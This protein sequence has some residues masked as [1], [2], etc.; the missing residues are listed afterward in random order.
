MIELIGDRLPRIM[1]SLF[2]PWSLPLMAFSALILTGA[3]LLMICGQGK[4]SFI[5]AL[6]MATSA[7]CV[8]GLTIMNIG[9]DL[10]IWGQLVI[11]T[12][13]QVGGLGIM[14]FSTGLMLFL[15]RSIS[16][17]S[18]FVLQDIFTYSP[19]SDFTSLVKRIVIFTVLFEFVGALLLFLRFV[20]TSPSWISALY[21]AIFHSISAFCNA[22]FSLFPDS[23]M[24][25][26]GDALVN[27]TMCGLIV[28]GGLGF[29]VMHEIYATLRKARDLRRFW[30]MLSL[31]TKVVTTSTAA[32]IVIGALLF[33]VSEWHVT[34]KG[35]RLSERLLSSLFQSVT[36]RTAGFNTLDFASMNNISI[37]VTMIFM[38]IG[39]SPGSTGGGIK[40]T[41]FMVLLALGWSR[42]RGFEQP[43]LFKR[44]VSN[45]SVNR[46]LV[47]FVVGVWI[48]VM[49]TVL[50]LV[51]E[52]GYKPYHET[53][54]YFMEYLFEVISAFGTV[55]LSMGVTPTLSGPG[56]LVIVLLM[57]IGRVGP[58]TVAMAVQA[59][60]VSYSYAEEKVMIG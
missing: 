30:N 25:F 9:T 5:D 43:F 1:R 44:T 50:L 2:T 55:G 40:T 38:F 48:V 14:T 42:F 37:F 17:R 53:E 45:D 16:F 26:R 60:S 39:A 46:A 18:R 31:H 35:F 58:L 41:S 22:G 47:V 4:L 3:I 21:Q 34:M 32:L 51:T 6:F 19:R 11:L 33:L 27:F 49:G 24:R 36:T 13:I 57:F 20:K 8:T 12:L 23:M 15:G 54:G 28:M 59:R 10:T 29:L 56:K 7:S 52:L